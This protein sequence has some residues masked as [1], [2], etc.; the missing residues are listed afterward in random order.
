MKIDPNIQ[1]TGGAQPDRGKIPASSASRAQGS[2]TTAGISPVAGEDTVSLSGTHAEIQK[3]TASVA[4]VPEV[5]T[6]RVSALQQQV[7]SGQYKPQSQHI[8]DAILGDVS[9]INSKA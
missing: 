5:R 7:S 9:G 2:S 3:L 8:A 1:I 4:N 6:D